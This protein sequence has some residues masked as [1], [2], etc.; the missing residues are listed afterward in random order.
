MPPMYVPAEPK[1]KH[2]PTYI[3]NTNYNYGINFYQPM[4]D[5]IDRKGRTSL[6]SLDYRYGRRIEPPELPWSDGRL[7]WESKPVEPYSRRELIRHAIDAEDQARE[8]LS[9]FKVREK[10]KKRKGEWK[11]GR[12]M[13]DKA[14]PGNADDPFSRRRATWRLPDLF[15]F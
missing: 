7:V 2:W 12:C 10:K 15:G 9:R 1:W 6:T 8:H 14:R 5:Y 11:L 13:R 3:Y 4:I